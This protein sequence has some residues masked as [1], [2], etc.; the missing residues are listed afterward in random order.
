M[1]NRFGASKT[2]THRKTDAVPSRQQVPYQQ[3]TNPRVHIS[4]HIVCMKAG[5][6]TN[7]FK[8]ISW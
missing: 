2:I 4:G 5:V 1:Q 6:T 3:C 7:I 8:F